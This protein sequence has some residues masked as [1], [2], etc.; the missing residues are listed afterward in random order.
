MNMLVYHQKIKEGPPKIYVGE[1]AYPYAD[2]EVLLVADG[3]GGRGGYPHS[4]IIR[5]I[6]NQEGFWEL[7]FGPVLGELAD[8]VVKEYAIKSF[9]EV[10]DTSDYYFENDQTMRSSGYFAS[11]LAT[12]LTLAAIRCNPVFS[13]DALFARLDEAEESEREG[14]CQAYADKLAALLKEQLETIAFQLHL[15]V[16][17]KMSGAYLLPSTL[18]L[19]LLKPTE[20]GVR[21]VYLW[22]GDSRAYIWDKDGLGQITEDHERDETMTNLITLSRPFRI[23][24]RVVE[25]KAPCLLFN[26]SDGVYKCTC[27]S[28]PMEMEYM[29]LNAIIEHDNWE[30]VSKFLDGYYARFGRHDDSNTMAL[31]SLGYAD[32][33]AVKE[34]CNARLA[35]FQAT[36]IDRLPDLLTVDYTSEKRRLEEGVE[37]AVFARS[38]S[39]I[40]HPDVFKYVGKRMAENKYPPYAK[41]KNECDAIEAELRSVRAKLEQDIEDWYEGQHAMRWLFRHK[42][43]VDPEELE[44]LKAAIFDGSLTERDMGRGDR[45]LLEILN[46]VVAYRT[47]EQQL[48]DR[49]AHLEENFIKRYWRVNSYTLSR[50]VWEHH[51][52]LLPTSVWEPLLHELEIIKASSSEIEAKCQTRDEIYADY[53]RVYYRLYEET[54]L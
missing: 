11:R 3:L 10:F 40:E 49:L 30:D 6:I 27:Y 52:E 44:R 53:D 14:I 42:P 46:H 20:E 25:A 37:E 33:A 26:A 7:V 51:E 48:A 12:V 38:F 28:N 8:D 24:A 5:P 4:K 19:A 23:E 39:W 15:E 13:K 41:E 16:E 35:D 47:K 22:A 54:K 9:H 2:N 34:A 45:G 21:A 32:Y 31:V 43:D 18:C 1:D 29:L 36:Y 50:E 17:T